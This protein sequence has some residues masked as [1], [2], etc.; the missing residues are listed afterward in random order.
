MCYEEVYTVD[1]EGTARYA[2]IIAFKRNSKDTYIID[3]TV[4]YEGNDINQAEAVH[5]E[6]CAMFEK[7]IK[8]Y[9]KKYREQFGSEI[10]VFM[11]FGL[12]LEAQLLG[13]N[14]NFWTR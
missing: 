6:K 2:D 8:F 1:D 5:K 12:V 3:Q 14:M 7:C 9:K 4:S 11:G 13:G 10:I